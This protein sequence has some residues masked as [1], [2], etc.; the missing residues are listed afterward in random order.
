MNHGRACASVMV[1]KSKSRVGGSFIGWGVSGHGAAPDPLPLSHGP[2]GKIKLGDGGATGSAGCAGINQAQPFICPLGGK[3]RNSVWFVGSSV[4]WNSGYRR[5]ASGS[6]RVLGQMRRSW[7][8]GPY[9]DGLHEGGYR[10]DEPA[11]QAQEVVP[12]PFQ[13]RPH[14]ARYS[15][16]ASCPFLGFPG[17][18]FGASACWSI[19]GQTLPCQTSEITPTS[20]PDAPRLAKPWRARPNPT[21][22]RYL[23]GRT[24]RL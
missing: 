8:V 24:A 2:W 17:A 10:L 14:Q 19:L 22:A 7:V 23:L 16:R 21:L 12:T 3:P 20:T 5:P 6:K 18:P 4:L 11:V 15:W 1:S 9:W 13:A